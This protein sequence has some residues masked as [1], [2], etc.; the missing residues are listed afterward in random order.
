MP[1]VPF[2]EFVLPNGA[3]RDIELPLSDAAAEK[4][5]RLRDRGLTLTCEVLRT[6]DG[7]FYISD[8]ARGKDADML[9]I[10][11]S[12]PVEQR[13]G[14]IADFIINFDAD[15]YAEDCAKQDTDDDDTDGIINL[16]EDNDNA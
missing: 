7:V 2:T 12:V 13:L 8:N 4:A 9:L 3:R 15:K 16:I 11:A 10:F 6:G 1:N 5:A 14:K